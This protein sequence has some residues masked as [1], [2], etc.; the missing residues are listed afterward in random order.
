MKSGPD[1]A[2][3]AARSM[4]LD[5]V[6]RD[7]LSLHL[8]DLRS[9]RAW[10]DAAEVRATRRG[11]ALEAAGRAGSP[12]ATNADVGGRSG[13]EAQAVSE[14]E[15]ICEQMP[16]LEAAL[17]AGQVS[18]G[19]VDAVA[20]ASRRLDEAA[21]L[22][23]VELSAAIVAEASSSS[24]DAFGRSV[25]DLAKLIN[26]SRNRAAGI[27]ELA[28]QRLMS[29]VE[30]WVDRSTGMHI[31]KL[32]L[33]PV[34]DSMLWT[35]VNA[36]LRSDRATDGTAKTPWAQLQVDAFINATGSRGPGSGE[37]ARPEISVLVDYS[38]LTDG[39]RVRSVCE[40][41]GGVE[42]PV[43]TVRRMCCDSDVIP[44]VLGGEREVLDAGRSRRTASR[45]Q[46]RALAAMHR[47]CAHPDCTVSFDACRMHHVRF[48]WEHR[49]LSNLDNLL[50][51]CERHHHLVHEGGWVVSM[52]PDRVAT[53]TRPD[54]SRHW[55]GTTIDRLPGLDGL[56]R[57]FDR[58]PAGGIRPMLC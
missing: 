48:W 51:V 43:A 28:A 40:T 38:T 1:V 4:V 39:I 44:I 20:S 11:R 5:H 17:D 37:R 8:R 2:F 29:N 12:I 10:V 34:R 30:R 42:L 32:S 31:T 6:S 7:E 45:A 50:P 49:G 27:D 15:G 3:A 16:A 18:S 25:R 36:Q 13:R 26:A 47:T 46:R 41:E 55:T 9:I 24:V 54:G 19:H 56:T 21:R 35:A 58:R 22:E 23:L 14:R 53:W 52:T 57:E 33:D